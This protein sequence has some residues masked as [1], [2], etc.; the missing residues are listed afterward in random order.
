MHKHSPIRRFSK[1]L[2]EQEILKQ[3]RL[4]QL[5][6]QANQSVQEAIDYALV[7]PQPHIQDLEK[8]VYA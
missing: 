2:L 5:Q 8:D 7:Q 4:D 3:D 6:K 1:F